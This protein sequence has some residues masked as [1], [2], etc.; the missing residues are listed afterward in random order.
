MNAGEPPEQHGLRL[1][2]IVEAGDDGVHIICNDS[3]VVSVDAA[4]DAA[5]RVVED[6]AYLREIGVRRGC[7]VGKRRRSSEESVRAILRRQRLQ[8]GIGIDHIENVEMT[9]TQRRF[10]G[11][12]TAEALRKLSRP[13]ART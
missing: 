8:R 11:R 7:G 13:T 3:V 6:G 5:R 2:Q 9:D 12:N 1:D 4:E 10:R